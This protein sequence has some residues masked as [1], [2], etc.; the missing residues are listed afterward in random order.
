MTRIRIGILGC[1]SIA[2]RMVMPAIR[3]CTHF[4]LVGVASRTPEK[5]NQTALN[6]NAQ[7]F[8]SYEDLVN[9]KIDAVYIPLPNS[10]HYKWIKKALNN[11][12]HV[13]SEKS[14]T[15]SLLQTQE[16]NTHAR[17]EGLVLI[18]NFQFR[19]HNQISHIQEIL[20]SGALGE[21]RNLRASFGVPPFP[22]RNNIRYQKSL[23]GGALLD[24]GAYPIK[25][26]QIFLGSDIYVDGASL[27]Y[28]SNKQVDICGSAF[29]KQKNGNLTAQIAFG[30]DHFYQNNLELWGTKGKL[31][32][33]RIFTAGPGIKPEIV[34][35][36]QDGKEVLSLPEDNPFIKILNHFANCIRTKNNLEDEYSQNINQAR[37]IGELNERAK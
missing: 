7:P 23:G 4:E 16:V 26:T 29:L 2:K 18:E 1:A 24:A 27:T 15:C 31:T 6:F 20:K 14:M 8:K 35:E 25:I 33:T 28:S 13:L 5:A 22:D 17:L 21:L 37:L 10:L 3:Q 32:A 12:L 30:F 19:F 9:A 36:N 11:Q 34:I